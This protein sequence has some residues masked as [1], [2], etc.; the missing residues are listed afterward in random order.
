[1]S[2]EL[3]NSLVASI[4]FNAL[5]VTPVILGRQG[6]AQVIVNGVG[7]YTVQLVDGIAD[8]EETTS[9]AVFVAPPAAAQITHTKNPA[10]PNNEYNVLTWAGN[11]AAHTIWSLNIFRCRTGT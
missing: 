11:V 10:A 9:C 2:H 3:E 6:I 4:T 5:A 8:G 7:D 1:M